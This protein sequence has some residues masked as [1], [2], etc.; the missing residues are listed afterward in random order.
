MTGTDPQTAA[1]I[2]TPLTDTTILAPWRSA[3][4]IGGVLIIYLRTLAPTIYNLDSAELTTA[5]ATGGLI[6]AT[7]YPLYLIVGGLWS[8]LPIGDVGY[9]MNLLS[10][11]CGAATIGLA[12]LILRRLQVGPWA[13]VGALGLLACAPYF[14]AL[15]LIA[16]VYTLHTALMAAII[17]LLLRWAD[18][19]TPGRLAAVALLGGLSMGHHLATTMLVPGCV[20]FVLVVAPRRA[21]APKSLALAVAV[22]GT[23]LGT[24]TTDEV[25]A[26]ML[27]ITTT[28]DTDWG[29]YVVTITE[30]PAQVAQAGGASAQT[31]FTLA[32]AA[33]LRAPDSTTLAFAVPDGI[34]QNWIYMPMIYSR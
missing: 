24:L 10:A 13:A 33:P 3:L 6:R 12:D 19:P 5:A 11:V 29:V 25:G 22:N 2:A 26:F 23:L 4:L 18:R 17:L 20:A 7:G 21:L 28:A 31:R 27:R 32:R 14:W 16:E 15:S 9:R 30:A 1:K 34:A 8:K